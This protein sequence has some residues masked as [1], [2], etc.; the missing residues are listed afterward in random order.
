MW[1]WMYSSTHSSPLYRVEIKSPC[2]DQP[3][4]WSLHSNQ[5]S[6]GHTSRHTCQTGATIVTVA[7][8]WKLL[9]TLNWNDSRL[10]VTYCRQTLYQ[11]FLCSQATSL[12]YTTITTAFDATNS[13]LKWTKLWQL[14]RRYDWATYC[15]K[16]ES[17]FDSQQVHETAF[18]KLSARHWRGEGHSHS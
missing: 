12:V 18:S 17:W 5:T 14:R 1:E 9:L 16:D 4:V 8:I 6:Q 10:Y 7:W 3:A 13:G 2:T 11:L 15:K